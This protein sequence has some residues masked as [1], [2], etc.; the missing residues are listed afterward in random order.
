ML[1]MKGKFNSCQNNTGQTGE[2]DILVDIKAE[3]AWIQGYTGM[4]ITVGVVDD[5]KECKSCNCTAKKF[6]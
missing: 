1:L 6:V 5:G 2:R 3:P 4:G